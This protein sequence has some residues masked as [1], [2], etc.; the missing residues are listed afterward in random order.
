MLHTLPVEVRSN[1][2]R[3]LFGFVALCAIGIVLTVIAGYSQPVGG[4]PEVLTTKQVVE[5][6][7]LLFTIP[8]NE[9]NIH[10]GLGYDAS[11]SPFDM[12][13]FAAG[14]D[15][16]FW[17]ID[18]DSRLLH[19]SPDGVLLGTATLPEPL[20]DSNLLDMEARG[21]DIWVLA[22][23]APFSGS[24]PGTLFKLSHS[25]QEVARYP[26]SENSPIR[27]GT[28]VFGEQGELLLYNPSVNPQLWQFL[29]SRGTLDLKPL[30]GY[31]S[32][33]RL[34]SARLDDSDY[35]Y[36]RSATIQAGNV[37]FNISLSQPNMILSG[38]CVCH[39]N[40]DGSFYLFTEEWDRHSR[41]FF[42]PPFQSILY[43]SANGTPIARLPEVLPGDDDPAGWL[44]LAWSWQERLALR[45]DGSIYLLK[46]M[47]EGPDKITHFEV[48]RLRFGY[49]TE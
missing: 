49:R 21:S 48:R 5:E 27:S 6:S 18:V 34:Y 37:K 23:I 28:I 36:N 8:V 22:F 40:P 11:T 31:T 12:R 2:R 14:D 35:Q 10:Y 33:G 46:G 24:M 17:I 15:G 39:V 1:Q 3:T 7:D 4:F 30:E 20:T 44:W 41:G 29:D 47:P 42:P 38:V 19:Y 45:A 9:T 13:S 32:Q 43:Y 25:G 26:F 16:T